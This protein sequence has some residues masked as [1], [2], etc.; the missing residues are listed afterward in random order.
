MTEQ[1]GAYHV[2]GFLE[3][4]GDWGDVAQTINSWI[5]GGKCPEYANMQRKKVNCLGNFICCIVI[6]W[7]L[8]FLLS[9]FYLNNL[10]KISKT[11]LGLIDLNCTHKLFKMCIFCYWPLLHKYLDKN[12]SLVS[13]SL[14]KCVWLACLALISTVTLAL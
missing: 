2:L 9:Y 12:H 1:N 7:Q 14:I 5:G 11:A 10:D 6:H 8:L 3:G 13:R 4:K